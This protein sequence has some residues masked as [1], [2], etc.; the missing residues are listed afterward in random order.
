MRFIQK[1]LMIN[2]SAF[3]RDD[4]QA[5]IDTLG[6][7]NIS[8]FELFLWDLEIFLQ[9]QNRLGDGARISEGLVR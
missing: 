8:R 7:N 1:A 2:E 5:R 3:N 6:F 4:I 9:L